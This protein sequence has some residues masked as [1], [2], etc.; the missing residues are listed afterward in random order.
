MPRLLLTGHREYVT[1][2]H[3]LEVA[4]QALPEVMPRSHAVLIRAYQR[5]RRAEDT[6][7]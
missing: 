5:S 4:R 7:E 6:Q 2:S 1:A 3:T